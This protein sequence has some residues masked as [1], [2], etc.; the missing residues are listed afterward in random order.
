VRHFRKARTWSTEPREPGLLP[1]RADLLPHGISALPVGLAVHHRHDI[2]REPV[3]VSR[4]PGFRIRDDVPGNGA[5][6]RVKRRLLG[7]RPQ[8]TGDEHI[9]PPRRAG[10]QKRIRQRADFGAQIIEIAG[11]H[12]GYAEKSPKDL[13]VAMICATAVE[14]CTSVAVAPG[15]FA[16]AEPPVGVPQPESAA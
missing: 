15:K 14:V 4:L 11:G 12:M 9:E 7:I 13:R 3:V 6:L 16:T 5:P 2:E 1:E 10:G 8:R